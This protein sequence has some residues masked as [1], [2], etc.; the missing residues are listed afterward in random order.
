M[1]TFTQYVLFQMGLTVDCIFDATL[2]TLVDKHISLLKLVQWTTATT[3]QTPDHDLLLAIDFLNSC[4]ELDPVKRMSAEDA[5]LHS[6]L[7]NA[8]EDQYLDD[9][10]FLT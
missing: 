5:L 6:F 4:M 9:E 10:V 2:P 1:C 8:E 3:G 7:S